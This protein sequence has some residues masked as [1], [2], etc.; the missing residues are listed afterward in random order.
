[1]E[2]PL[3]GLVAYVRNSPGEFVEKLR[4][5][6]HPE[7]AHL[8]AHITVLPPRPLQGTEQQAIELISE[9]C[10]QVTPF[11]VGLGDVEAFLPR[12][13]TVFIRVARA[14]YKMRELHD[15]LNR[16]PLLCE[17]SLPYMPHLTIAKLGSDERAREVYE[18]AQER[19]KRYSGSRNVRI[20]TVTFVR[21]RNFTWSD[22]APVQLG[23]AL[24]AGPIR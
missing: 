19:W 8:S 12:T 16:P 2:S 23:G 11:E 10:S 22:V 7:H 17:E 1:M 24:L 5:E 14:A 4:N 20:E 13:P 15:L 3:Y 18:V 9:A 6:L 21:G